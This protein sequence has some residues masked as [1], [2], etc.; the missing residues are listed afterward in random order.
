MPAGTR[1]VDTLMV[2][3]ARVGRAEADARQDGACA[4]CYYQLAVCFHLVASMFVFGAQHSFAKQRP[5]AY[6]AHGV[7]GS[8]AL[9]RLKGETV[10]CRMKH[11]RGKYAR[12]KLFL[13]VDASCIPFVGA[14]HA[15]AAP[16]LWCA[17]AFCHSFC[18][19]WLS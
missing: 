13:W 1:L 5:C 19:F 18:W 9:C 3:P 10:A 14:V 2:F 7:A 15:F 11:T 17:C 16:C 12:K 8:C 6:T 4:L